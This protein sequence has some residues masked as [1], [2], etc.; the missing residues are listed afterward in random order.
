MKDKSVFGGGCSG[1][2][3]IPGHSERGSRTFYQTL[4]SAERGGGQRSGSALASG[5]CLPSL[6]VLVLLSP[7]TGKE[8]KVYQA[9]V[10]Q[11]SSRRQ[12]RG[13]M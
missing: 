9:N 1:G 7:E 3:E 4:Q 12:Q 10:H 6:S 2:Q 13:W 8:T 11:M 5:N